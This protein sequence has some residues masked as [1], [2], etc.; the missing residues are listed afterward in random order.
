MRRIT[1]AAFAAL[2]LPFSLA[3]CGGQQTDAGIDEE[4]SI[5]EELADLTVEECIERSNSSGR[6]IEN[7]RSHCV[8]H[9]ASL[10]RL[11]SGESTYVDKNGNERDIADLVERHLQK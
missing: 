11:A 8:K 6:N 5:I 10:N 3:A 7:I 1:I 9:V 2:A 4:S